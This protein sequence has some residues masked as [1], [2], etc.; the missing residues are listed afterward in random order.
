MTGDARGGNDS[1]T[2][3]GGG[4]LLMGDGIYMVQSS[5]GGDDSLTA[6]G[7]GNRLWGDAFGMFAS[8]TGGNDSLTVTGV[9]TA[10]TA[11]PLAC[12]APAPAA[13]TA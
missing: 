2:A 6:S 11:M 9:G 4:N 12:T 1:L 10:S 3:S 13:T 5:T 7:G 8:S